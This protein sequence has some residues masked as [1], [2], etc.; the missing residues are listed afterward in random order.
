[1]ES[2]SSK[3]VMESELGLPLELSRNGGNSL[4]F[5]MKVLCSVFEYGVWFHQDKDLCLTFLC[6]ISNTALRVWHSCWALSKR[7]LVLCVYVCLRE[8]IHSMYVCLS[9]CVCACFSVCDCESGALRS[10]SHHLLSP[11][12][13]IGVRENRLSLVV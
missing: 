8:S 6:S 2:S 9:V 13:A 1:M 5:L 7:S 12:R 10:P 4:T 3:R 11:I